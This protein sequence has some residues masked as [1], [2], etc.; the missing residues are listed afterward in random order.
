[1][2]GNQPS[3][4]ARARIEALCEHSD[5]FQ[6]AEIDLELRGPGEFFGTRQHGLPEMH[7]AHPVQDTPLIPRARDAAQRII[8]DDPTLK[9]RP[10]RKLREEFKRR[11]GSRIPLFRIG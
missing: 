3:E 8:K 1:M 9:S 11:Y 6:I 4:I 2:V 5:G 7:I 10:Y